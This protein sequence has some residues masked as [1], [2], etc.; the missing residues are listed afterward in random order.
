MESIYKNIFLDR[1]LFH[2]K[3]VQ[4]GMIML[5]NNLLKLN[6]DIDDFE[7][8]KRA[9]FHDVDKLQ[10]NLIGAYIEASK[11]HYNK[12]NNINYSIDI[13]EHNRIADIHYNTQRHHFYKNEIQSPSDI[14][15][16]EMCC[17]ITAVS[18]EKQEKDNTYYYKNY[19]LKEYN[20]LTKY[21][22]KILLVFN[23]LWKL[24]KNF[25]YENEKKYK[26]IKNKVEKIRRFQD[27]MIFLEKN[28]DKLPFK[29][30]DY[31]IFRRAVCLDYSVFNDNYKFFDTDKKIDELEICVFCSEYFIN[32]NNNI[33]SLFKKNKE[34]EKNK[35][36]LK[37]ILILLNK[38][39][40]KIE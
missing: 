20:K 8:F 9:M 18:I 16:C 13:T 19:M 32:K 25:I 3:T 10:P 34:L 35:E 11:Y 31:K 1:Y 29:I 36:S 15:I 30:E 7:L 4:D 38:Q 12:K 21:N 28:N 5:E 6:L 2:I 26:Y 14:D 23:L 27:A 22:N 17:D 40:D 37:N 33:E 24:R 39:N